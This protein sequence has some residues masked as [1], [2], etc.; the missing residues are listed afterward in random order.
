MRLAV[1]CLGLAA[2]WLTGCTYDY[3]EAR[4]KAIATA[5]AECQNRGGT[6][7]LQS[8]DV[9][10]S[11]HDVSIVGHCKHPDQPDPTPPSNGAG[12]SR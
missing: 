6:F 1:V 7:I 10:P 11:S 2:F 9:H 12:S 8:A 3:A 4:S 5:T